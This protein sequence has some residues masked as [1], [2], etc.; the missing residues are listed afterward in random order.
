MTV[1][2]TEFRARC[3]EILR[4]AER[5]R[6]VVE[7][8]RRGVVVAR[9]LPA[10]ADSRVKARPWER[11]RGSG[12]LFGPPEQGSRSPFDVEGADLGLKRE[13]IVSAIR[14]SREK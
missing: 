2:V 14:D 5:D 4:E 6:K 10:A 12:M 11:L 13:Q 8:T 7:I 3:L 9:L 1:S